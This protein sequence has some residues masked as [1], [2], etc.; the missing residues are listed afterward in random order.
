MNQRRRFHI[1]KPQIRLYDTTGLTQDVQKSL[2]MVIVAIAFGIV[3]SNIT[4]GAAWTGF[5]RAL[6]ADAFTLGILSAIP[7]TASTF[8]IIASYILE[9]TRARRKLLLVFGL[10][11]RFTW[12][13]IGLIPYIIPME[14]SSLRLY[15]LMLLLAVAAMAGSFLNVSFYS[16]VADLVPMRIR[17]RYFSA[18]Q[19][20]SLLAG[21]VAGLFVS[22]LLDSVN[23]YIGYTIVL[24]LAGVSGMLDICC[25]FRV[26]FPPM[27]AREGK[28][29]SL[30]T[31]LR[32]V[33]SDKSYMK[34]VGY[35]TMWFFAVNI[36]GPFTNVYFL[37]QVQMTYTEMTLINQ[38]LQNIATVF[39]IGWWGRQMDRFGN[40][41]IVQT[42]GLYCMII[43]LA[44][45]FT[46]P[47]S[48]LVLPFANILSGLAWPASDLGQQ[49]MYLAK[50]PE[51]N[52]SMYIAVFF[53]S[54]QLF[55]TALSNFVGGL[56][57]DGPM[58]SLESLN[59]TLL[60]FNMTR[61][62]YLFTI[63]SVLRIVCVV[64][65]LPH[66][67]GETDT[68]APEM[69]KQ[70]IGQISLKIRLLKRSVHIKYLR[71]KYH[72]ENSEQKEEEG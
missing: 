65:L 59:L 49:N 5:Q 14:G 41:P 67:R 33:L 4:T 70:I 8:Q 45:L 57:M 31:M 55:G 56:L 32:T 17:G 28:G 61:Y 18:R 22:W 53:A 60:G 30:L 9:K 26:K 12:V 62:D 40:Q 34:I 10:I 46:G 68:P 24:V 69:W 15:A 44:Y 3:F 1:R 39:I 19:T 63:S 29:E 64:L 27:Q 51:H 50:A 72:K 16:L 54:T 20:V 2:N 7:V 38:I 43:P 71:R 11:C 23:G 47:R 37:E 48:F 66:L 6:G 35:F 25:F 58:I 13:I 42:A 52:R 36:I 21:I